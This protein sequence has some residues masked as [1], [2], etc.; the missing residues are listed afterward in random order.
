MSQLLNIQ[1]AFNYCLVKVSIAE[2]EI[3]VIL[4]GACTVKH[5][6]ETEKPF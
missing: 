2:K 1:K 3:T 5:E 4:D 6:M